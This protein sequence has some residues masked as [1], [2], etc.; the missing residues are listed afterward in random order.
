MLCA[1]HISAW[2]KTLRVPLVLEVA[3]HVIRLLQDRSIGQISIPIREM[4]G[5]SGSRL[6]PRSARS[7]RGL[8]FRA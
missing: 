6:I 7:Y 1:N 5:C 4:H 3:L 2:T 8:K